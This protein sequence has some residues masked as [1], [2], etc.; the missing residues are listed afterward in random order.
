MLVCTKV[1]H[2]STVALPWELYA[3]DLVVTDETEDD[4]TKGLISGRVT[5]RIQV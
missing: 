5:W 1:Q 2:E 3:D 4:L